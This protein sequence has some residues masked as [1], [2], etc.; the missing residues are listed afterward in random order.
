[1]DKLWLWIIDKWED[2]FIV[3]MSRK[4]NWLGSNYWYFTWTTQGFS[5]CCCWTWYPALVFIM[6]F[7]LSDIFFYQCCPLNAVSPTPRP[8]PVCWAP[9]S[10]EDEARRVLAAVVDPGRA[11]DTLQPH[12][13]HVALSLNRQLAGNPFPFLPLLER[14]D[15]VELKTGLWGVLFWDFF[16]PQCII[17]SQPSPPVFLHM[18]SLH[19]SSIVW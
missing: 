9:C 15:K 19:S 5:I 16:Y 6:F 1:M 17:S 7:S 13:P 14:S 4:D 18:F 8:S 12:A 2:V 10:W 3:S 11:I